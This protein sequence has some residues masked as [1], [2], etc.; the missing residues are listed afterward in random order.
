MP[1]VDSIP[2][3]EFIGIVTVAKPVVG[4]SP[5]AQASSNEAGNNKGCKRAMA[6]DMP[7]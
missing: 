3:D 1:L 7:A 6:Q 4:S 5:P 2:V